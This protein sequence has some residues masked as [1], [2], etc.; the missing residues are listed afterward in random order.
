[1]LRFTEDLVL[2]S[3]LVEAG[4]FTAASRLTG[5]TKSRLSRRLLELEE[6]LGVRLIERTSRSF[7]A[8]ELALK[9]CQY[10]EQIRGHGDAALSLVQD[11]LDE[12]GGTLCVACPVVLAELV[13]GQVAASFGR[14][15]PRVQM[16]FDVTTGLPNEESDHYDLLLRASPTG[17]PDSECIARQLLLSPYELVASP[18]WIAAAGCP[19][20]PAD[21]QGLE[22][23][24]WWQTGVTP[25][26]R[27]HTNTGEQFDI[28]IRP[29]FQTNNLAVARIAALAGVGMA[30]LPRPLC[31]DDILSG[32]LVRVLSN[33]APESMGIYVVYPT[34]KSLT[35]AGRLFLEEVEAALRQFM[36]DNSVLGSAWSGLGNGI[37]ESLSEE[38][39]EAGSVD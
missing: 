37:L 6:A 13:V 15:Y 38:P 33:Y 32:R 31:K 14:R 26:W 1:L 2:L 4:S 29:R 34:R 30:R 25:R 27:L 20:E 18:Q 7:H 39:A 24:G 28:A 35:P 11:A 22:G 10:G 12:P 36:K 19:K 9:L 23:I 17:L 5:I 16:T 8:T 3:Q 21:L